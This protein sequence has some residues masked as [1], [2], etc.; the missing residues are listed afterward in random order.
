VIHS[1]SIALGNNPGGGVWVGAGV[2]VGMSLAVGRR[3][4]VGA[5]ALAVSFKPAMAVSYARVCGAGTSVVG[6][7]GG[8]VAHADNE[9]NR[10]IASVMFVFI[11]SPIVI[12]IVTK[13]GLRLALPALGRKRLGSRQLPILKKELK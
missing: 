4:A 5:I 2:E 13:P 3:V 1:K 6:P 9:A 12:A 10:L 11:T 7:A 8:L